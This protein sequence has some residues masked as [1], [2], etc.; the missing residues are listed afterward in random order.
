MQPLHQSPGVKAF[1]T[2]SAAP[3]TFQGA[4][5]A[6]KYSERASSFRL[7]KYAVGFIGVAVISILPETFI[8]IESAFDG[9]CGTTPPPPPSAN[10]IWQD[11][12]QSGG[13]SPWNFSFNNC[14]HPIGTNVTC[15]DA[16]GANLSI[17]NDP[18]G[19]PGKALRHYINTANGG[20]CAQA[21]VITW[22]DANFNNQLK[23]K[24]D[25]WIEQ[26]VYIPSP[27]PSAALAGPWLNL[28]SFHSVSP[29]LRWHTDPGLLFCSPT[30]SI[31]CPSGSNG[32]LVARNYTGL[33]TAGATALPVPVNQWFK[34]Q[35]H[36][37]WSTSPVPTD[38]YI[39]GAKVLQ[40]VAPTRES[41]AQDLVEW[42]STWYGDD[43]GG[44]WSP[45][46]LIRYSRNVK[47]SDAP[48]TPVNGGTTAPPPPLSGP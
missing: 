13:A 20:G 47:V 33:I 43:R 38:F 34:L 21:G 31:E 7:T 3:R 9:S 23:T 28:V 10:L 42:Y 40:I 30:F 45:N 46:P 41:S 24:G 25:V 2:S 22:G 1:S 48:L 26:E 35:I 18:A 27:A 17:V 8:S 15:S 19:G 5:M 11:T 32:K 44:A 29:T 39:N 4:T 36:W 14:E 6:T 37:I 12:I 16:N